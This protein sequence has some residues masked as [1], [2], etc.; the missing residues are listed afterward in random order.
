MSSEKSV[1]PTTEPVLQYVKLTEHALTPMKGSVKSAGYDFRSAHEVVIP[2]RGKNLL[3]T[4]LQIKLPEGYYGQIASR[5][6]LALWDH[7][8]VEG[9]IIDE[10]YGG[11]IDVILYNHS[12]KH[13]HISRGDGIAQ[14]IC[15][16]ICYPEMVE[17][18]KLNVTD[19]GERGFGSTGLN[20]PTVG[21]SQ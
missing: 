10:D 11:S 13:F 2:A 1:T 12:D 7:I 16:K 19:R 5:S 3:F 14:L 4:D 6:G 21:I 20:Q 17:F 8:V 9:D 15:Q 18:Y